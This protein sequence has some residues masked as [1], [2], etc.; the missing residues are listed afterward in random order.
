MKRIFRRKRVGL[1]M[2]MGTGKTKIVLDFCGTMLWHERIHRILVICPLSVIPVWLEEIAKNC[3][4]FKVH[5]ARP[6]TDIDWQATMIITNYAFI[7]PRRIPAEN[8]ID[9]SRLNAFLR[10]APD[11]VIVDESHHIKKHS[12]RIAKACKKLGKVC[13]YAICLTGTPIGNRPL[14]LWSQFRFLK[15]DLLDPTWN[16]FKTRYGIWGGFGGFQLLKCRNLG[17]LSSIVK[18]YI[19]TQKK[20]GLPEKNFIPYPVKMNPYATQVYKTMEADFM[21]SVNG[22]KI[23]APIV[24]AK[25]TKLS[26]IT[27]GFIRDNDGH[28]IYLHNSKLNALAEILEEL[29]EQ[30][31]THVVIFARFLWE[32]NSIL[33]ICP[34]D[35]WYNLKGDIP[36]EERGKII[37]EWNKQGGVLVCQTAVGSE[38]QNLQIASYTIFYSVDYSYIN[39]VQAQDRTHRIGQTRPCFY[40]LLRCQGTIDT[41]I[42]R[43]L[44]DKKNIAEHFQE[45]VKEM[46]SGKDSL[47]LP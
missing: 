46:R 23:I 37:Q 15:P 25:M 36:M 20:I 17:I 34:P 4:F 35:N 42:Y 7:A 32:I 21:T 2:Q 9:S 11:V 45:L 39:F 10:W 47:E 31:T 14:D 1:F 12:T 5:V 24:L 29:H 16:A 19:I 44:M 8:R 43:L 40:Y 38:G 27:G 41:A 6:G 3:P 28:D 33:G 18:P 13:E 30:D 26:Q 22:T